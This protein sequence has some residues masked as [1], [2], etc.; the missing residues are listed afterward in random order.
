RTDALAEGPAALS[1]V[2][3]RVLP[4]ADAQHLRPAGLHPAVGDAPD[5]P[6]TI[7]RDDLDP[8]PEAESGNACPRVR[9][10]KPGVPGLHPPGGERG[11]RH[12]ALAA[13]RGEVAH[14][15]TRADGEP[16]E[17]A[18]LL[19]QLLPRPFVRSG[20]DGR[21]TGCW[22]S[23]SAFSA[24]TDRVRRHSGCHMS[25]THRQRPSGCRRYASS[26]MPL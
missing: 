24:S 17:H 7:P 2:R 9:S 16:R 13:E 23:P 14:L 25:A 6:R 15:P 3:L 21:L 4:P 26:V 10:A 12:A 1:D 11:W 22:T 5:Q 20:V 19:F 18:A 8:V